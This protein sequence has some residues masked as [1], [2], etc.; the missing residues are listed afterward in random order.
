MQ[1]SSPRLTFAILA[2]IL[3]SAGVPSLATAQAGP[4][5]GGPGGSTPDPSTPTGPTTPTGA[6]NGTGNGTSGNGSV[7][8]GSGESVCQGL[9]ASS[10]VICRG[11]EEFAS[12]LFEKAVGGFLGFAQDAAETFVDTMFT[13]IEPQRNGNDAYVGCPTNEPLKSVCEVTWTI[14]IPAALA[15]WLLFALLTLFVNLLPSGVVSPMQRKQL[16][17][18]VWTGG[19][20]IVTSWVWIA[21]MFHISSALMASFAPSGETMVPD[22]RG[23]LAS[24]EAIG[25]VIVIVAL[26]SGVVAILTVLVWFLGFVGPLLAAPAVPLSTALSLPDFWL[27]KKVAQVGEWFGGWFVPLTFMRTVSAAILGFGYPIISGVSE[28]IQSA[29]GFL[30][31]ETYVLLQLALWFAALVAPL[32]LLAIA[33]KLRGLSAVGA[34]ALGAASIGKLRGSMSSSGTS[35]GKTVPWSASSLGSGEDAVPLGSGSG[36]GSSSGASAP[37][38]AASSAPSSSGSSAGR[39]DPHATGAS[40]LSA[41]TTS[42]ASTSGASA[43][44]GTADGTDA[45]PL[46]SGSSSGASASSSTSSSTGA[47]SAGAGAAGAT[48]GASAGSRSGS[49]SSST[50]ASPSP[51]VTEVERPDDLGDDVQYGPGWYNS[52]GEWQPIRDG[53]TVS[54]EKLLN[55]RFDRIQ[56]AYDQDDMY[57]RSPDG[58]VLDVSGVADTVGDRET[59]ERA[60]SRSTVYGSGR[61]GGL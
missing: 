56:S 15:I 17:Q 22:L 51:D 33:S 54:G 60:E 26:S 12:G 35:A 49:S 38:A 18:K 46:G 31:A 59:A 24:A 20:E 44:T 13:S 30:G 6:P 27:F 55:G 2:V 4:S 25:V 7:G 16:N 50:S 53:A 48:S 39:A 43:P 58:E 5:P 32:F 14:A 57:I 19:F 37:A 29:V 41:G 61:G 1:R 52:D 9:G 47:S 36:S 40:A 42:P 8:S 11:I 21:L 45:P 10:W 3:L 23:L 34:A 28:G